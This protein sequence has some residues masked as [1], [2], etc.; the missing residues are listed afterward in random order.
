MN[1]L[2]PTKPTTPIAH[3]RIAVIEHLGEPA[4]STPPPAPGFRAVGPSLFYVTAAGECWLVRDES[5]RVQ[6]APASIPGDASEVDDDE[7]D[8]DI[9]AVAETADTLE[10]NRPT[11]FY[12]D[13]GVYYFRDSRASTLGWS[14]AAS[15]RLL[16][17]RRCRLERP[18]ST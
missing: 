15:T 9:A 10:A 11:G 6:L 4:N 17:F 1:H 5:G 18:R 12:E 3:V 14:T 7:I 2:S 8:V 16:A 13:S